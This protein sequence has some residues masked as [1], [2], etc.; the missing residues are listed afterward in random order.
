[1]GTL[2]KRQHRAYQIQYHFVRPIKYREAILG[3]VERCNS[4]IV[5]T[6]ELKSDMK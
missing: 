2:K 6:K 1:M 4:L 5:I 3:K